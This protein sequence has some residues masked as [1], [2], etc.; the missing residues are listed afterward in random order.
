LISFFF[1]R[2]KY[3]LSLSEILLVLF[4]PLTNVLKDSIDLISSPPTNATIFVSNS[5]DLNA[6]FIYCSEEKLSKMRG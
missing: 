2:V 5:A 6:A 1:P 4:E 3:S